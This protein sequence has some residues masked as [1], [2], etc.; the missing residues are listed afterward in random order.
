MRGAARKGGPYREA[1]DPECFDEH[2]ESLEL[3]SPGHLLFTPPTR[4]RGKIKLHGVGAIPD[5]PR[6]HLRS[7]MNPAPPKPPIRHAQH[8]VITQ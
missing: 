6:P 8:L 4:P 2:T 1:T 3:W 7:T 5:M